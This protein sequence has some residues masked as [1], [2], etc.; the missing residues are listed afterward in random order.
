MLSTCPQVLGNRCHGWADEVETLTSIWSQSG[1][2]NGCRPLHYRVHLDLSEDGR[3]VAGRAVLA[4]VLPEPSC[5]IELDARGMTFSSLRCW[6]KGRVKGSQS[7]MG[8]VPDRLVVLLDRAASGLLYLYVRWHRLIGEVPEGLYRVALGADHLICTQLQ[9]A[10]A[11]NVFPCF[12]DPAFRASITLSVGAPNHHK[13]VANMPLIRERQRKRT[14][15]HY[16]ASS[17]PLPV[18]NVALLAGDLIESVEES[19]STA[20]V[21]SVAARGHNRFYDDML[22]ESHTAIRWLE[23]YLGTPF[24][25]TKLHLASVPELTSD[26]TEYSGL[27]VFRDGALTNAP[28]ERAAH[29][30]LRL[31]VHELAHQWFGGMVSPTRWSDVWL[32]EGPATW[33]ECRVTSDLRPGSIAN[34]GAFLR[35]LAAIEDDR[36]GLL[37]AVSEPIRADASEHMHFDVS[38]YDKATGILEAVATCLGEDALR[39]LLRAVL[40]KFRWQTITT[41]DFLGVASAVLEP[42]ALVWLRPL[43]VQRGVT[44]VHVE[45]CGK[46]LL[47][48][49]KGIPIP[50]S[51]RLQRDGRCIS[52]EFEGETISLIE[53]VGTNWALHPN[54][55]EGAWCV[56]TLPGDLLERLCADLALSVRERAV[57][58]M[59][60]LRH[61]EE[62]R[63]GL[64]AAMRAAE[65]LCHDPSP[66]VVAGLTVLVERLGAA[67]HSRAAGG[68]LAGWVREVVQTIVRGLPLEMSAQ[69]FELLEPLRCR[70]LAAAVRWG[71]DQRLGDRLVAEGRSWLGDATAAG[72]ARARLAASIAARGGGR[73]LLDRARSLLVAEPDPFRREVLLIAVGSSCDRPVLLEGLDL[74]LNPGVR[75]HETLTVLGASRWRPAAQ[76]VVLGWLRENWRNYC[77]KVGAET[78]TWTPWLLDALPPGQVL[79]AAEVIAADAPGSAPGIFWKQGKSNCWR[80]G[81]R[82]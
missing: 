13:V 32:T 47:L 65:E 75:A 42:T 61:L 31:L 57:L 14:V 50:V 40:D 38:A 18:S 4:L 59:A 15:V 11:K 53:P 44:E 28:D 63:L 54:P 80:S 7:L 58:P 81:V 16:F 51:P 46:M 72:S 33:L 56:W 34:D 60:V 70:L 78:A 69:E 22:E 27:I 2:R 55:G 49:R 21:R 62:G 25:F 71:E 82:A 68:A 39:R 36:I 17:P 10:G 45:R 76:E 19:R 5:R 37:R 41:E 43:V 9:P 48:H 20:C 73:E 3:S 24:P 35:R 12:D 74:A 66:L 52:L 8:D 77:A 23:D 6:H 67:V 1:S 26:A 79:C 30:R 29:G 64:R